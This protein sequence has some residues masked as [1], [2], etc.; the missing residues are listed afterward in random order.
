MLKLQ[1]QIAIGGGI[2]L[3]LVCR[4][5]IINLQILRV[6]EDSKSQHLSHNPY[7][8]VVPGYNCRR[9]LLCKGERD[10]KG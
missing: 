3:I 6:P 1:M 5:W 8:A 9:I 10:L 2:D 4:I 7:P